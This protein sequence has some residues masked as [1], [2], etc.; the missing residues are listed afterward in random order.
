MRSDIVDLS[1]ND[2][3]GIASDRKFVEDFFANLPTDKIN[4]TTSASRLLSGFQAEYT[5]LED[6]LAKAY[7]REA[8]LFNSGYHANTG[9]I[10]ALGGKK[11]LFLA[12]KLVHASIIDGLQLA[13]TTGSTYHRFRHNDFEHLDK[14]MEIY[15]SKFDRVVIIAES[16]YS[17]DGD[18]TN[19]GR[20]V[21]AKESHP[22]AV[23]YL[24]EA[25]GIG[26]LGPQGLGLAFGDRDYSKVDIIV[27]TFGKALASMGAF[28]VISAE[29]KEYLVNTA[30]SLIFSTALPPVT[31]RWSL[32][33]LRR[34][35][36]DDNA[37]MQL[38]TVGLHLQSILYRES[39]LFCIK[40]DTPLHI[41]PYLLGNP[42]LAVEMSQK[43]SVVGFRV[44][45]IRTPTVPPGTDRLRFSLS[46][47]ITPEQL[48]GLVE[49]LPSY[50]EWQILKKRGNI[51]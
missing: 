39:P 16:V 25:H 51:V 45:P 31:I 10:K 36:A 15:G 47:A 40:E 14:L 2:Y 1:S 32:A 19:I 42:R 50:E 6:T 35:M 22:N 13:A 12:D 49:V 17:M 33:T 38:Q 7:G 21:K 20:L 43:L 46:A 4:L 26:I 28:A 27:G 23:I 8:L 3:L 41:Q 9:I 44:L 37:R 30:R 24:D 48:D 29:L 5:E 11:T 34:S 18:T